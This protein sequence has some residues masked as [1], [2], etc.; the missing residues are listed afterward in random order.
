MNPISP[1]P[2]VLGPQFLHFFRRTAGGYRG[3]KFHALTACDTGPINFS[4]FWQFFACRGIR[5]PVSEKPEVASTWFLC[6]SNGPE[7]TCRTRGPYAIVL[8]AARGQ[9]PNLTDI[10]SNVSFKFLFPW[11]EYRKRLQSTVHKITNN[12]DLL[13]RQEATVGD[14]MYRGRLRWPQTCLLYT[15]DAADE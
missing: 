4:I 2:Y 10:F 9:P 11:T 12:I 14:A 13:G 15:S 5:P 7:C 1:P 8:Q 6:Q 3:A